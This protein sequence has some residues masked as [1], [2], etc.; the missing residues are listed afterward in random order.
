MPLITLAGLLIILWANA[1]HDCYYVCL[2]HF[3]GTAGYVT[4]LIFLFWQLSALL[5]DIG[6]NIREAHV[7][8]TTDGYSLDVFVVDGW[9]IEVILFSILCIELL[10]WRNWGAD[11]YWYLITFYLLFSFELMCF[12]LFRKLQDSSWFSFW[13]RLILTVIRLMLLCDGCFPFLA[14]QSNGSLE[15]SWISMISL[16]GCR[17]KIWTYFYVNNNDISV[18]CLSLQKS[19]ILF[20]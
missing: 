20:L 5:S 1:N 3:M 11:A 4:T 16:L 6:L 2:I 12:W 17:D 18:Q 10:R 13:I 15:L 8:S 7:F 14:C 19:V 9:P